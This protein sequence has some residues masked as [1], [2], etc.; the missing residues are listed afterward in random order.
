MEKLRMAKSAFE[1]ASGSRVDGAT[2]ASK[3]AVGLMYLTEAMMDMDAEI[4]EIKSLMN[5]ARKDTNE[6]S[7]RVKRDTNVFKRNG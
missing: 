1:Q 7:E 3:T 2:A 6:T 4:Q 5:R